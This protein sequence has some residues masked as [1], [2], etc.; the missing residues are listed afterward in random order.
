MIWGGKRSVYI[1]GQ[2]RGGKKL[3]PLPCFFGLYTWKGYR[4]APRTLAEVGVPPT[5]PLICTHTHTTAL[6]LL[7]PECRLL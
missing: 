2:R 1:I 7:T 6:T 5:A 4:V 3:F